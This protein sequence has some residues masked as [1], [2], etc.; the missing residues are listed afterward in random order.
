MAYKTIDCRR[1]CLH[2]YLMPQSPQKNLNTILSEHS[3]FSALSES[4]RQNLL[5]ASSIMNYRDDNILFSKGEAAHKSYLIISGEVSIEIISKDGKIA[6]IAVLSDQDILGEFTILDDGVRSATARCLSNVTVLS[7]PKSVFLTLLDQSPA[8]SK[9]LIS[10]LVQR[11]R[12]T[13]S[14]VEGLTLMPLH[15]RLRRLLYALTKSVTQSEHPIITI[16]QSHLANRL[17]ASREKVNVH[18]RDL[19]KMGII[20]T[21]RGAIVVLRPDSLMR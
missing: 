20:Q 2:M 11:L 12:N 19:Q 13:N 7:I 10:L 14:L 3:L 9:R 17:S 8:L 21:K 5:N 15:Q 1:Q 6:N 18:L 4:Q 16:T